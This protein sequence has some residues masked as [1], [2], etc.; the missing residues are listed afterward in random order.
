MCCP[1]RLNLGFTVSLHREHSI[2]LSSSTTSASNSVI[3]HFFLALL[4]PMVAIRN[5][6]KQLR[7]QRNLLPRRAICQNTSGRFSSLKC[8]RLLLHASITQP[9]RL[10]CT[11]RRCVSLLLTERTHDILQPL[12]HGGDDAEC[13]AWSCCDRLCISLLLLAF[14]T[15]S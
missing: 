10:W 9:V 12:P 4:V 1:D 8:P 7:P 3:V 2:A 11:R 15:P 13:S 6:G 14:Q 5:R